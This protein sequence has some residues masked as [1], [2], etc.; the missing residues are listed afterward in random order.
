MLTFG[1]NHYNQFSISILIRFL[2]YNKGKY[3]AKSSTSQGNRIKLLSF[4]CFIVLYS[5]FS[6]FHKNHIQKNKSVSKHK[7]RKRIVRV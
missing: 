6:C 1:K 2:E 3:A 7:K 5:L 4:C